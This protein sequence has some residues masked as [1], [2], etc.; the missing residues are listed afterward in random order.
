MHNVHEIIESKLVIVGLIPILST[1]A[2]RA[3][4]AEE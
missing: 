2:D 3:K 1:Q 4:L